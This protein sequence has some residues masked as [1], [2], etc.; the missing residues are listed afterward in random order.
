MSKHPTFAAQCMSRDELSDREDFMGHDDFSEELSCIE[1]KSD[2][3]EG[4]SAAFWCGGCE[5]LH[6]GDSL[7]Y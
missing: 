4:Y 5:P 2:G 3:F 6:F 7:V 1:E